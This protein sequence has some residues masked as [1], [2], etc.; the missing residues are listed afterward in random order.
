MTLRGSWVEAVVA[1]GAVPA[2]HVPDASLGRGDVEEFT[3]ADPVEAG[4]LRVEPLS[5]ARPLAPAAV[6]FLDGIEQWRV[7]GYGGITPIVRAHVAAAVRQRGPDRRL[8]TVAEATEDVAITRL[9]RLPAGVR[10]ALEAAGVRVLEVPAEEAGQP[11]RAVAAARVE[12][13][14]TRTALERRLGEAGLRA[15]AADEWLV[16]DGVLSDSAA[17][18]EHTRALGVVKSHGA[19]YFEGAELE[20]AL[21]LPDGHRTSVFRPRARGARRDIYSWYVRLWPWEGNDLLYGL[22][23]L[24]ARA[25]PETIALASPIAA[26]MRAER[27][28]V[29]TPDRRWDR[30]LYPIHDVETY[31][32]ARAPSDL[33]SHPASRIPNPGSRFPR[34]AS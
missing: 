13:Q 16:V 33:T 21:T 5:D 20:R 6:C 19:Q 11:A 22:L 26:W 28:P 32:R 9:D 15:L 8:R 27:A 30:L 25:H 14:K 12:V 10:R 4:E 29:A 18:S 31:L 34:T 2:S 7:V 23:R 17:L 1:A 3:G 24:E